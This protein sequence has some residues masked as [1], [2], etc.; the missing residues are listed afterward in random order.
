MLLIVT[1]FFR[2]GPSPVATR[3]K[4]RRGSSTTPLSLVSCC[5]CW[6]YIS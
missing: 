6:A 5:A 2:A 4:W 3:W 1:Y